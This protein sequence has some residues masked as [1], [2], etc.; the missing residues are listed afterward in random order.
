[1]RLLVLMLFFAI[2]LLPSL[3]VSAA[4]RV[5]LEVALD[6]GSSPLAAQ[7]WNRLLAEA[8]ATNVRIRSRRSTD[9][10]A[11]EVLGS[12]ASP[13]YRVTGVINDRNQLQLPGATFSQRDGARLAAWLKRLAEEGPDQPKSPAPFGLAESD[14]KTILNDLKG[15]VPVPTKGLDRGQLVASL[16]RTLTLPVE[17]G[18]E[19]DAALA[20]AGPVA[21]ELSGMSVGVALAALLRPAGL[22]FIPRKGS[23]GL[24]YAI[25]KPAPG[26]EVWPV[27]FAS[28]ERNLLPVLFET[29]NVEIEKNSLGEVLEAL[30]P[31]LKAPLLVDHNSLAYHRIDLE[32]VEVSL[33]GKKL[34]Y[35]LILRKVLGQARLVYE[36]R[37]DEANRLFVWV[38]T[39]EKIPAK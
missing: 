17:A 9:Q 26:S 31:R 27:G 25:V 28:E 32:K 35:S 38:T 13:V 5:E 39:F 36:V 16:R 23:R 22:A 15:A 29:I 33:P 34:A 10:A 7:Q 12:Q 37:V 2:S 30:A 8:Q 24:L 1:M 3:S 18:P 6:K 20:K 21:E 11:I 4:G 19:V 14:F